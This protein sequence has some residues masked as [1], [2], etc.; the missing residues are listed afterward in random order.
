MEDSN[1][2]KIFKISIVSIV[3]IVSIAFTS[4]EDFL[5]IKPTDR[6]V[7]EDFWEDKAD[8]QNVVAAAYQKLTGMMT[9]YIQWGECRS[10]NLIITNGKTWENMK[11]IMNANLLPTQSEFQWTTLYNEINYCNK[12]LAHGPEVIERD[13]SFSENDW[14]PIRAEAITLRALMHFYLVRVW[15]EV[16]YVTTDYNNDSQDFLIAQ[17]SQEQVLTNII[18]DLESVKDK[19][20]EDYGE[21][22]WN[23]GRVTKKTVRALL[24]DVYLWRANKNY[25]AD[26]V[27]V[28]G[29][30][31]KTDLENCVKCCE[32][33]ITMLKNDR[34][35]SLN[36]TGKVLGGVTADDLTMSDMLIQNEKSNNNRYQTT[37][38]AYMNIFGQGNSMESIFEVQ[39]D[40]TN[41]TNGVNS[42][43]FWSI[44][45][46]TAGTLSAS[47]AL[48]NSLLADPNDVDATVVFTRADHRRWENLYYDGADQKE[49]PVI[50][51][52]MTSVNQYNGSGD[53]LKNN[54]PTSATDFKCQQTLRTSSTNS[55]NWIFYRISDMMLMKAE[56][57]N[58]LYRDASYDEE[59]QKEAFNL[60]REIFYRSNPY[61]YTTNKKNSDPDSLKFDKFTAV[62]GKDLGKLILAERQREFMFEGKRWFDL[63]RYAQ[64][65][66]STADMLKLLVRKYGDNQNAIKAKLSTITSLFS[67]IY[68]DEMKAN[69]LLHQNAVWKDNESTSKTDDL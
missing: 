18:D 53:V 46:K 57:L 19:A 50:K 28:Y 30:E 20:M 25:S 31:W 69:K 59:K 34:V 14:E 44:S 45:N 4:C 10:D 27:A 48:V 21:E 11:D 23:K 52:D 56:A 17:S 47:D 60:V 62:D 3:S 7:E 55:A 68:K 61:L 41:N 36:K 32:E 39:V 65:T 42:S 67:P 1:M 29:E 2:K 38:G 33:V 12:I 5:T 13:L 54:D 35:K 26:S 66:G 8:L 22:V 37:T 6:I 9:N 16:P 15:G 64:R 40:G 63:V 24:A 58:L 51:Y 43:Y 49:Y